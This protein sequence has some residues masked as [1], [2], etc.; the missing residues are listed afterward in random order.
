MRKILWILSCYDSSKILPWS[1]NSHCETNLDKSW[2]KR[3]ISFT[4][5]FSVRRTSM[6][7]CN[8]ISRYE[9][10]K[11]CSFYWVRDGWCWG[12]GMRG[13]EGWYVREWWWRGGGFEGDGVRGWCWRGG[14]MMWGGW[15]GRAWASPTLAWLQCKTRVYTCMSVCVWQCTENFNWTNRNEGNVHFKF[16]H[17]LKL[18]NVLCNGSWRRTP[19][20]ATQHQWIWVQETYRV[21]SE[22]AAPVPKRTGRKA[23]RADRVKAG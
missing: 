16:A 1:D 8:K 23:V 12:D 9:V 7:V 17:V 10:S 15:L 3:G 19:H 18:F 21:W 6:Y 20:R 14:M 22:T 4:W 13:S 11:F 5:L 2:G